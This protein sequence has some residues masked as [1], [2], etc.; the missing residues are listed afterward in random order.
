MKLLKTKFFTVIG[1][2]ICTV[3]SGKGDFQTKQF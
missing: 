2:A 3:V 1:K